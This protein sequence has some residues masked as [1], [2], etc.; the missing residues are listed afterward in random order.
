MRCSKDIYYEKP[1]S[2]SNVSEC[3]E[4]IKQ[5]N[6]LRILFNIE[7]LLLRTKKESEFLQQICNT[8]IAIK[9]YKL[10][11]IGI[12]EEKSHNIIPVAQSGFGKDYRLSVKVA[13]DDLKNS[14]SLIVQAIKTGKPSVMR[15]I[16][17]D[18][19]Y[20]L[21]R[22]EGLKKGRLSSTVLPFFY[23]RKIIGIL[24]VYSEKKDSFGDEEVRF[25]T[26][27]TDNIAIG[28]RIL[29][30][31]NKLK[32]GVKRYEGMYERYRE[33]CESLPEIIFEIDL[34]GNITFCNT[35]AFFD[36]FGY[37]KEDTDEGLNIS[38]LLISEDQM[39]FKK[40][41]G[42]LLDEKK[43]GLVEYTA[44]SKDGNRFPIIMSMTAVT[45]K[46]GQV[47]GLRGTIL[48][49]TERKEI[50]R[51]LKES[52]ELYQ[53]IFYNTGTAKVTIEE[54]T[55]ISLANS[56]FEKLSGYSKEEIEGKKSWTE[57]VARDDL[58][59]LMKCRYLRKIDPN[60]TPRN[61]ELKFIDRQDNVKD[62]FVTL[63]RIP[64]TEKFVVAILDITERKKMEED[65]KQSYAK[66][67]ELLDGTITIMET[68][69]ETKDP[70]ISGHQKR[71]AKLATDIAEE[72]KLPKDKIEAI[73]IAARIHDLGK[74]NIPASILAKT[75]KLTDIEFSMIRTH[76]KLSYNILKK[77]KFSYPI[78]EIVHQHHERLDGSGYPKGL[79]GKDIRLEAKILAVADVVEAMC[80]HR[81]YRAALG[82]NKALEEVKKN[83]GILYDPD[84][85]N[86]CLK[87]F[88]EGGLKFN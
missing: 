40:N 7:Q 50:E 46:E 69:S 28:I 3:E 79:K 87:V 59:R 12:I 33:V 34:D 71:V 63:S 25:L 5:D 86:A 49:I 74:I 85:V 38:Q 17:N 65:L 8:L 26:K 67:Q 20:E 55:T 45:S 30:A 42:R 2:K 43:V 83:S 35:K 36:N 27:V 61:Y 70:Y 37:T 23:K 57:F 56:A 64:R 72:M 80:S 54:D 29:R 58:M 53:S 60:A 88:R 76:P 47:I 66:L 21:W 48:D 51:K 39:K 11:W 13:W 73:D 77:V 1:E 19:I 52:E 81:P 24:N 4:I 62:I 32:E 18:P 22:K 31:E 44:I 68:I 75:G 84:V 15:D 82:V 41:I 6:F 16:G 9:E 10:V 78:A 14:G